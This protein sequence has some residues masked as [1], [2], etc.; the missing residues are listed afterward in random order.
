MRVELL[1]VWCAACCAAVAVWLLHRQDETLRRARVLFAQGGKAT[2]R[3]SG[4]AGVDRRRRYGGLLLAAVTARLERARRRLERRL[5]VRIGLEA[6]CVPVGLVLALAARSPVPALAG[7]LATPVVGA[8]LRAR[9]ARSALETRQESVAALCAALAGEL[10]AGCPPEAALAEAIDRLRGRGA[11]GAGVGGAAGALGAG[12]AGDVASRGPGA[13]GAVP[14]RAVAP[15]AGGFGVGGAGA[16]GE[17]LTPLLAAA[18]FGGDVP[19]AL[20]QTAA[21]PGAEGLSGAAACWEVAVEGGAGLADG[22]DRVAATLRAERDQREELRAQLAGPK[23]TAGML[24]LLPAFG[25]LLGVSLGA[26]PL[27]VLFHTA[28]GIGCLLV[29]GAL[30]WAGL[31]WT[32]RIVRAAEVAS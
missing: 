6:W 15:G 5:G 16:W 7:A 29:G 21:V 27:R 13:A 4:D 18:R 32:G 10:R 24:A 26:D 17:A 3:P 20:R 2:D 1:A 8:R 12:V 22:L 31:A 19:A 28:T 14:R 9:V 11:G 30:E 25:V 23:A